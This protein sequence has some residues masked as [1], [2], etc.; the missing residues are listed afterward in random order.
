MKKIATEEAFVTPEVVAEWDKL[1]DD[2]APAEPGFK[3]Q[4]GYFHTATDDFTKRVGERLLELGDMRLQEM[5]ENGIDMQLLSLTAPGVQ[6]FDADTGT[7]LARESNDILVET[8]NNNPTRYAGLAAVAPQAPKSAAKEL[9]RA[10]GLG[11]K[12]AI[13][14]SHTKGEYLDAVAYRPILEAA[15][16]L[17]VPIYIHPNAVAPSMIAPFAERNMAEAFWGFQTETA[18]HALRLIVT[19]T[20]DRFPNLKIVLGHLGEG[21]PFWLDRF[22]RQYGNSRGT[23][24]RNPTWKAK[25]LPSD[26]FDENFYT[27][28]SGHN[29]DPAVRFVEDIVGEDRLMFGIDYPYANCKQQTDQAATIEL[30]NPSKFYHLNAEKVFKL[31]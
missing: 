24:D 16:S 6:V 13:I 30:K 2:G 20:F 28:S 26:Y 25:R 9:E 10:V 23:S 15:E 4:I 12:G 22:D 1:L 8:V 14:N 17:D 5:D 3:L 21:I 7:A 29:W 31:D 11:L 19:G 27:T 18:L